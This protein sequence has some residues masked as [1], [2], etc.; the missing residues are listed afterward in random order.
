MN[1]E[2]YRA[3]GGHSL[4]SRNTMGPSGTTGDG[5]AAN[6]TGS[7]YK[8]VKGTNGAAGHKRSKS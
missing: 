5:G 3:A 8:K 6:V 2:S 4:N 7:G 1:L